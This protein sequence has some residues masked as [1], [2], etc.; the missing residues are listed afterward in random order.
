MPVLEVAKNVGRFFS[1]ISEN[2]KKLNKRTS[3]KCNHSICF[4][5]ASSV[6][7]AGNR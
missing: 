4:M 5:N 2:R 7:H 3:N 1:H 6:D